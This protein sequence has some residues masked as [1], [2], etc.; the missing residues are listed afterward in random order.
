M[1]AI[2]IVAMC[3]P[4]APTMA[5]CATSGR[6]ATGILVT[7]GDERFEMTLDASAA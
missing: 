5:A 7:I 4:F 3:A 2:A 6:R 1:R